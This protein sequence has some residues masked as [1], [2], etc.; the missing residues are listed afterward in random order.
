MSAVLSVCIPPH[1]RS[2][3]TFFVC[4]FV[5]CEHLNDMKTV[6]FVGSHRIN[7]RA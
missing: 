4:L 5:C 7:L 2:T 6:V 1:L 3:L